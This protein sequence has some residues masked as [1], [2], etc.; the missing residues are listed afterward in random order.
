MDTRKEELLKLHKDLEDLH[1]QL[2]K[3]ECAATEARVSA[4][5]LAADIGHKLEDIRIENLNK[6]KK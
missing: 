6:K 5:N 3:L 4:W 2:D 1:G